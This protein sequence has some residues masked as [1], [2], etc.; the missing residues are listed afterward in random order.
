MNGRRAK[1]AV[2]SLALSLCLA[3]WGESP[4]PTRKI[5][6]AV[7]DSVIV[8]IEKPKTVV[9]GDSGIASVKMMNEKGLVVSGKTAGSTSLIVKFAD[10]ND[11][12][13]QVVVVELMMEKPLIEV[14]VQ[15]YEVRKNNLQE[16]GIQ[17][18][19]AVKA[20]TAAEGAIP[21][22]FQVDTLQR[23]QKVEMTL[24]YLVTHGF[25]KLLA[26]PRLMTV[27]GGKAAFLAGGEIPTAYVDQQRVHIEYKSYGVQLDIQPTADVKGNINTDLRVE[28]SGID[29]AN[30]VVVGSS[31]IPALRTRWAKTSVMIKNGV[32][33]VIAGLIQEE[34]RKKTVGLP[35]LSEIPLVGDLFKSTRSEHEETELVIFVSPSIVGSGRTADAVEEPK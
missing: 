11:E 28:V 8:D 25:A 14:N 12:T 13:Y 20:L 10:G 16:L 32:T 19:N 22:L 21:P 23:A 35:L 31:L 2:W 17:W 6:L 15:V 29:A 7:G 30:S 33:L 5:Q 27:S 4:K 24:D 9:I 26:K 1:W 18:G 34:E 3:G